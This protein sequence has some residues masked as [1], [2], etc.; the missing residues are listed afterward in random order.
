MEL[1]YLVERQL[2][3]IDPELVESFT[4]SSHWILSLLL[5]L[6]PVQGQLD[7]TDKGRSRR[8]MSAS[9]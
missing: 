1:P 6:I 9:T 5:K 7:F 3:L 8:I 2:Y 4:S